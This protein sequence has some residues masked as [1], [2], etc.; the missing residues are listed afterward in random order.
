MGFCL[1][2]AHAAVRWLERVRRLDL[3]PL[4]T[5]NIT[6]SELLSLACSRFGLSRPAINAEIVGDGVKEAIEA[7]AI[8]VVSRGCTI[9]AEDGMVVT[10]LGPDQRP[11][12]RRGFRKVRIGRNGADG[13]RYGADSF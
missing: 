12:R 6:D 1:V 3:G 8:K 10:V 13:G 5:P 11:R 4:R 2:T 7:G 9:I